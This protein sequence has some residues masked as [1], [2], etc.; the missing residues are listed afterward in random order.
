MATIV[1]VREINASADVVFATV[2]DPRRFAQAI[3]GVTKLDIL[4]NTASGAGTRY[5]QSRTMKGQETTMEFAVTDYARNERV[6]IVNETHGT[7]WDSLF[8]VAPSGTGT[9]LAMRMETRSKPIVARWLMPLIC[10]FITK[11]VEQDIQAVKS[12]C[13]RAG[14]RS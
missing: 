3:S 2:A 7:V 14:L 1:V 13:E 9:R 11:A 5:R 12:C 10:L 4:S 8:T 6:R